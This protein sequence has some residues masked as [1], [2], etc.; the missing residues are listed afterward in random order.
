MF[1]HLY[2]LIHI[3]P[4]SSLGFL[5]SPLLHLANTSLVFQAPSALPKPPRLASMLASTSPQTECE[6]LP[7]FTNRRWKVLERDG[8]I[9]IYNSSTQYFSWHKVGAKKKCV[10]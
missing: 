2:A 9:S 10:E 7:V 3:A 5:P 4:T 8:L 6:P 1:C